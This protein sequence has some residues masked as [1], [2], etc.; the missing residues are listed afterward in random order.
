MSI[1]NHTYITKSRMPKE[2]YFSRQSSDIFKSSWLMN[3]GQCVRKLER[4][5][6]EYLGVRY[7][8]TGNNGTTALMLALQRAG[9]AGRKVPSPLIRMWRHFQLCFGLVV[10]LSSWTLSR[11]AFAFHLSFC[12]NGCVMSLI[13][14]GLCLSIFM[15]WL[16]MWKAWKTFAGNMALLSFM[17]RRRLS[18]LVI[19]AEAFWAIA[20][21][22]FS[23]QRFSI[24]RKAGV[25][26]R[27]ARRLTRPCLLPAPLPSSMMITT[28]WAST[29]NE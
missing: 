9:L 28:I 13:S 4:S 23:P 24:L 11:T 5:L 12:G 7:I 6:S 3:N 10:G 16:V 18:V 25:L 15:T 8:L 19:R 27:L 14:P 21:V 22:V 26:F 29:A 17:M 20:Y 2:E 1:D